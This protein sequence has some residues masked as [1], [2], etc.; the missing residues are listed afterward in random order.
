M[1]NLNEGIE[2]RGEA[3]GMA[4]GEANAVVKRLQDH[5][6]ISTI[7]NIMQY[8]LEKIAEAHQITITE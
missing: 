3:R 2:R 1:C 6:P 8:P 5:M 7:A 4:C